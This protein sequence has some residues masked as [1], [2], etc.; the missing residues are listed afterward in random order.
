MLRRTLREKHLLLVLDN[1]EHV[2]AAASDV[3]D[4]L[5]QCP[6]VKALVTSRV[7]LRL[8]GE[9]VYGLSPLSLPGPASLASPA[10]IAR[11]A[12][13]NL[14]VERAQAARADFA[15]TRANAAT[16]AHICADLDGLPLAIELAAARMNV[17]SPAALLKRIEPRLPLLAGGKRDADER[18]LTMRGALAWSYALLSPMEQRCFRRL[19]V[20]LGGAT[21]E[22]IEAICAPAETVT[23]RMRVL[24]AL[25]ALVD[26][27]LVQRRD[28]GDSVSFT[29]L[30]VVREFAHEQLAASEHVDDVRRAH[31]EWY[32]GYAAEAQRGMHDDPAR[33][34]VWL[35]HLHLE[36]DNL[37]AALLW[38]V[39]REQATIA[40]HLAAALGRYWWLRGSY[41]EGLGW[42]ERVLALP[43]VARVLAMA[44]E[45]S[46]AATALSLDDVSPHDRHDREVFF[47]AVAI[48]LNDGLRLANELGVL[49]EHEAWVHATLLLSRQIGSGEDEVR[50]LL[51]LAFLAQEQQRPRAEAVR[52]VEAAQ[53]CAQTLGQPG[54]IGACLCNLAMLVWASGDLPSAEAY[55]REALDW[56]R[57]A[58]H[59]HGIARQLTNL[60]QLAMEQGDFHRATVLAHDGIDVL[61]STR[62]PSMVAELL[63]V[64]ATA[65]AEPRDALVGAR[66]LGAATSASQAVGES[67][68]GEDAGRMASAA[69]YLRAAL[70][71][72]R[73]A[74]AFEQGTR[75]SLEEA[76]ALLHSERSATRASSRRRR[77]LVA[78]RESRAQA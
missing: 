50:A 28:D 45:P 42:F 29:M 31:A 61:R 10:R 77:K 34:P 25:G 67:L 48:A 55:L 36:R 3:A 24:D 6:H 75:M 74:A 20:F 76:L 16:V 68:S 59:P 73:W 7:P 2:A 12:A 51:M 57:R 22:A 72:A 40:V 26:H 35:D 54:W 32:L 13:V 18:H 69:Q 37:R 56:Q 78:V 46:S 39:E 21:L 66:L 41:R 30:H 15:L 19:A 64:L 27:C 47:H 60:A 52:H 43:E 33:E 49:V 9:R 14:F 65:M 5:A 17:L 38:A 53:L 4:I 63:V 8:S 58:G 23:S 62:D 11:S 71:P 44:R 1:F 70:G